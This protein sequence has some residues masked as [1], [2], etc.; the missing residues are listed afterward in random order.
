MSEVIGKIIVIGNEEIVGSA[1]TF[2]KRLLVVETDEQY[3]QKI[4]IDF[5]QD[6]CSLLDNY[7]VGN[8]VKVSINIRGNEY[9]SKYYVSLYGW[10]IEKVG[11][12]NIDTSKV[13][14]QAFTPANDVKEE[15]QDDLPF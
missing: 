15:E 1:G 4:P 6:K 3:K 9:N 13:P 2:K 7:A 8:D 14:A 5:V 10:R 12:E 11:A